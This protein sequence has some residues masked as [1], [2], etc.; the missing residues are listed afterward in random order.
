MSRQERPSA[1]AGGD[2]HATRRE[3]QSSTSRHPTVHTGS[4]KQ[5]WTSASGERVLG[6]SVG[7]VAPWQHEA[8]LFRSYRGSLGRGA[9]ECY[10]LNGTGT[11]SEPSSGR[12]WLRRRVDRFGGGHPSQSW[13]V[14]RT[15]GGRAFPVWAMSSRARWIFRQRE[16]AEETMCF[17]R[18]AGAP[19]LGS[20]CTWCECS[21]SMRRPCGSWRARPGAACEGGYG[22]R[23]SRQDWIDSRG[24]MELDASTASFPIA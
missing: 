24:L 1:G 7:R 13:G 18:N 3:C 4:G 8:T 11:V 17:P 2:A 22:T 10:G 9:S 21:P 15:L 12:R 19:L 23:W 14:P 16:A 20:R 5:Q 6:N